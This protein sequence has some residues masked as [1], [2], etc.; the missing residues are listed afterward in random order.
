MKNV[1]FPKRR[2]IPWRLSLRAAGACLA[3]PYL[4]AMRPAFSG[5]ARSVNPS[6]TRRVSSG[7]HEGQ[8]RRVVAINVDPGFMQD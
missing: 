6:L 3:L 5:E 7:E 2:A 4:V 1:Y 8:P